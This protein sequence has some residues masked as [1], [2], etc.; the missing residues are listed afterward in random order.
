MKNLKPLEGAPLDIFRRFEWYQVI[1][2]NVPE[3]FHGKKTRCHESGGPDTVV[4][5]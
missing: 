4:P 1:C 5:P 2:L 3:G